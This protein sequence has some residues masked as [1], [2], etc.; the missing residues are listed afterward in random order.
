M[1]K[2]WNRK[3]AVF[4]TTVIGKSDGPT[5]IFIAGKTRRIENY[6]RRKTGQWKKNRILKQLVPDPHSLQEVLQYITEKYQAREED[7]AH[8]SYQEGYRCL[9]STLIRRYHP[10][11]LEESLETC[12][13][14]DFT[15]TEAL[16]L[17]LQKQCEMEEKVQNLPE[18]LVPLDY[19]LYKIQ[20]ENGG[21]IQVEME[22]V[23]QFLG[24]NYTAPKQALKL[25]KQIFKE[26]YAYYGV[27]QKDIDTDSERLRSLVAHLIS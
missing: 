4:A 10:E 8:Y 20:T 22:F 14:A 18:D 5:S 25:T 6:F 11:L 17:Y 13:P 12:R 26:I 7:P 9:K 1:T 27:S 15:D 16:K 24:V 2:K 3:S 19:R 23:H 21:E